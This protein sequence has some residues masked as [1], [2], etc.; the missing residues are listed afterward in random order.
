[1]LLWRLEE[2]SWNYASSGRFNNKEIMEIQENIKYIKTRQLGRL[3]KELKAVQ[4]PQIILDAVE[5]YWNF[6]YLDIENQL[7]EIQEND[8][9]KN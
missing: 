3:M 5:K 7:K 8:S 2:S 6:F 9:N 4:T 1:M